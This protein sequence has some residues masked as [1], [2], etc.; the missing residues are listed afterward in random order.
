M[1][2][3]FAWLNVVADSQ[4]Q[5]AKLGAPVMSPPRVQ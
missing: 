3:K 1:V 5:S 4:L 2:F